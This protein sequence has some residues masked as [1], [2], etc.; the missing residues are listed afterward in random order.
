MIRYDL[1]CRN[2]HAF[3][4]WFQNSAAYDAQ[5][6]L[7]KVACPV[8]GS[9]KIDKQIMAPSVGKKGELQQA[10]AALAKLQ[11]YVEENCE[12]VGPRF[13]EEARRIHYG[14]TDP[15]GIYGEATP[16]EASELAEEGVRVAR[17]PL[18][19]RADS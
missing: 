3:E 2:D 17:L 15:R 6:K 10:Q 18:R 16:Q 11:S 1:T 12:Y 19:K 4:G 8:C 9:A 5:R 7:R 13:P 14:E